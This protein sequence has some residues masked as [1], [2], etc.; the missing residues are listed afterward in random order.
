MV[1]ALRRYMLLSCCY[2]TEKFIQEKK[3]DLNLCREQPRVKA[4]LFSTEYLLIS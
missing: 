4:I 3:G 2:V 1:P